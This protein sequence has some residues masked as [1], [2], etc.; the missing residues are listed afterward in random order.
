MDTLRVTEPIRYHL[1]KLDPSKIHYLT[2]FFEQPQYLLDQITRQPVSS[3]DG[4][5]VLTMDTNSICKVS[6]IMEVPRFGLHVLRT[7]IAS[8]L[9]IQNFY[10]ERWKYDPKLDYLKK[11]IVTLSC[12]SR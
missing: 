7:N 9:Q 5:C 1:E 10:G 11:R 8:E 3:Y 2:R 4:M 6:G 12:Q